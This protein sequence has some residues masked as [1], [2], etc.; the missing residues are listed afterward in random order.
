MNI[1]LGLCDITYDGVTHSN[2]ASEAIFK[3][4]PTYEV[5]PY[6]VMQK[7]YILT[8]Y[9]VTLDF[10]LSEESYQTLKL[11]N[12]SLV[13]DGNGMYDNPSRDD[14]TDGKPL[15]IHPVYLGENKE[16]DITIF[17]AYVDPE[18]S[19]ER[20]YSKGLDMIEVRFIGQPAHQFDNNGFNSH[21]YIGDAE[22][23]GVTL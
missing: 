2:L 5:I 14:L 4:Q 21:F 3:A 17:S 19:F 1:P 9:K 20:T 18:K 12:A 10:A 7:D 15:I 11:A 16:Y 8:D 22:K 6:G 23:A 13:D